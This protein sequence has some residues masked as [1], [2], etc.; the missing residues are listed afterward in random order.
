MIEPQYA[1]ESKGATL[2]GILFIVGE[3][4]EI[5]SPKD[6]KELAKLR[7]SKTYMAKGVKS[8][9]NFTSDKAAYFEAIKNFLK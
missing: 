8:A 2:N 9:E 5:V 3:K 7:A 4:D 1:L 6:I